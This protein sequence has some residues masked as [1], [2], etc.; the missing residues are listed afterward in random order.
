MINNFNVELLCYEY[1]TLVEEAAKRA[2]LCNIDDSLS[3]L[4]DVLISK[5]DWTKSA[6]NDLIYM[7]KYYGVF[8][9]RNALALAIALD[10]QD[11][12]CGY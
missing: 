8:M 11:G 12:K 3:E 10:C 6:A 9:L 7:A 1:D 2:D 4:E 5:A